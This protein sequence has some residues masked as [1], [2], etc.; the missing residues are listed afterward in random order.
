MRQKPNRDMK[1]LSVLFLALSAIC[2]AQTIEIY[3]DV[4]S[5]FYASITTEVDNGTS[6]PDTIRESKLLGTLE[7]SKSFVYSKRQRERNRFNRLTARIFEANYE[8]QDRA[9]LQLA[10]SLDY[11]IDS[12]TTGT[13]YREIFT[14]D[15]FTFTF[16]VADIPVGEIADYTSDSTATG[17]V[18]MSCV[19][20]QNNQGRYRVRAVEA[21]GKWL[22]TINSEGD[23]DLNGWLGSKT[24][25]FLV[26]DTGGRKLFADRA[27]ASE[28]GVG[29][30]V[31]IKR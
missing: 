24:N 22:L 23:F 1:Y 27:S 4:D 5:V 20:D 30:R 31:I 29:T 26:R 13:Y 7:Q 3:H 11:D 15:T 8:A 28:D 12:V 17:R 19:I 18:N 25:F 10:E 21:D 16:R 6:N 9:Y 14:A 2:S